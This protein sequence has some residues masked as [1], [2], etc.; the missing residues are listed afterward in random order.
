MDLEIDLIRSLVKMMSDHDL[1]ELELS[2]EGKSI[3]L[4]RGGHSGGEMSPHIM[5]T[6]ATVMQPVQ[7]MHAIQ[8]M[9]PIPAVGGQVIAA[10]PAAAEIDTG[11]HVVVSPMVG[12]FYRAP[13]PDS[14]HFVEVGDSIQE[15]STLAIIEAMKVMNEI[16]AE[17]SGEIVEILVANGEAVEYAQPLF[18]IRLA[19]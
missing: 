5:T 6:G 11:I 7:P 14:D 17:C 18:R 12:T 15:D 16:N 4:L 8:A 19:D 1:R 10:Q 13:S 3:R 9:Q 2:E